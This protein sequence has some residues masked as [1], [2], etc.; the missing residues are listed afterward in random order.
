[1]A[2]NALTYYGGYHLQ[3]MLGLRAKCAQLALTRDATLARNCIL[4]V[5]S[6]RTG[7]PT[8]NEVIA[9]PKSI[10]QDAGDVG[11]IVNRRALRQ[12]MMVR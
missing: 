8:L 10:K 9:V 2:G 3:G 6:F 4:P 5:A 1:M 12:R 7:A 11:D